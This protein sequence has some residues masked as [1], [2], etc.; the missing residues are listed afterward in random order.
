MY[1]GGDTTYAIENI[2]IYFFNFANELTPKQ[3]IKK[4]KSKNIK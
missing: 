3:I 2:Q 4:Y 1:P